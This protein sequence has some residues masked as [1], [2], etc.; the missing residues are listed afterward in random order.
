MVSLEEIQ[1]IKNQEN[2]GTRKEIEILNEKQK[3]YCQQHRSKS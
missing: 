3:N 2:R 1:T